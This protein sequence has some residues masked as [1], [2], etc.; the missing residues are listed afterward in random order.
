[1]QKEGGSLLNG[2]QKMEDEALTAIFDEYAPSIY[3]YATRFTHDPIIADNIVG[4]VFSQ[5]LDQFSAGK[6]PRENLRSYLF[7]TAYHLAVDNVRDGQHLAP[8]RSC[9]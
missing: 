1:M 7:Q 4:D 9:K 6:G 2:A 8:P 5:L 3:R